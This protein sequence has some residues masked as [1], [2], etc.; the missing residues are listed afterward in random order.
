MYD[1]KDL[2][3]PADRCVCTHHWL[4]HSKHKWNTLILKKNHGWCVICKKWCNLSKRPNIYKD[5]K[6]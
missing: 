4:T 2:A 6:D 3:T 1:S 5:L